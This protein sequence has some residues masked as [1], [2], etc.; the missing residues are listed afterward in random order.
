MAYPD[1]ERWRENK[2]HLRLIGSLC[3][4]CEKIIFPKRSFCPV[5]HDH[6]LDDFKL[7]EMG[8]VFS[9]TT[10]TDPDYAPAGF[11]DKVPYTMAF[12]QL[13]GEELHGQQI[14]LTAQLTD[15]NFNWVQKV[16]EGELRTVKEYN[17]V[18]GM[19]VE[20]VT[21]KLSDSGPDGQ[22]IYGYMFRPT[23]KQG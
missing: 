8:S 5:N 4:N 20:M 9:F 23:L 3:R 6:Q 7:P 17:V 21:R 16:I 11:E 2:S 22:I 19:P 15:L 12:I 10:I 18:I 14:F 13:E 1:L